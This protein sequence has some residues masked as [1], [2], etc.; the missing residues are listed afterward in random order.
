MTS[1]PENRRRGTAKTP[2][3]DRVVTL[4]ARLEKY[5]QLLKT[6]AVQNN[7]DLLHRMLKE[8][9]NLLEARTVKLQARLLKEQQR[10]GMPQPKIVMEKASLEP[11]ISVLEQHL[12]SYELLLAEKIKSG[13]K[14]AANLIKQRRDNVRAHLAHVRILQ[15]KKMKTDSAHHHRS[16]SNPAHH[17]PRQERREL[18]KKRLIE[19]EK[20]I[21][22]QEENTDQ[23]L[24]V[25][26]LQQVYVAHYPDN[27]AGVTQAQ[28]E[29]ALDPDVKKSKAFAVF[30][31]GTIGT[32]SYAEYVPLFGKLNPEMLALHAKIRKVAIDRALTQ[33][34]VDWMSP[35][36]Y[37]RL[38]KTWSI[39]DEYFTFGQKKGAKQIDGGHTHPDTAKL[40]ALHDMDSE[41]TRQTDEE[42]TSEG[43][44]SEERDD[45]MNMITLTVDQFQKL[46]LRPKCS[47]RSLD[48]NES[49]VSMTVDDFA[50][51]VL[52]SQ[53]SLPNLD[54][55][56]ETT[57]GEKSPELP[58]VK[59]ITTHYHTTGVPTQHENL[60]TKPIKQKPRQERRMPE[61][62][63]YI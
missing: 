19:I 47:Q 63:A 61:R 5:D 55:D 26:A 59:R 49:V 36:M 50:D 13:D 34:P 20:L 21:R 44:D 24:K 3:A 42:D 35:D 16:N 37:Q 7:P 23:S 4:Q 57:V 41:P 2:T 56:G 38:P 15:K 18:E 11:R 22:Q 40:A 51:L 43:D 46:S 31:K 28:L 58:R 12:H 27:S 52:G 25:I 48:D 33:E 29:A 9:R 6:P 32:G 54:T 10:K 53:Q 39:A 60:L 8:R 30:R 1:D 14:A 45:D 17:Q 62:L